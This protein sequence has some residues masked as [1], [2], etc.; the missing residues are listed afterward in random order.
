MRVSGYRAAGRAGTGS[1]TTHEPAAPHRRPFG[2]TVLDLGLLS[3]AVDQALQ[4]WLFDDM[5]PGP[6]LPPVGASRRPQQHWTAWRRV[7]IR[8]IFRASQAEAAEQDIQ[9]CYLRAMAL[10]ITAWT[11]R[12]QGLTHISAGHAACTT[13]GAASRSGASANCCPGRL[14]R[15][16]AESTGATAVVQHHSARPDWTPSVFRLKAHFRLVPCL[17]AP[18]PSR[19]SGATN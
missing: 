16:P 12:T 6:S 7:K 19:R 1:S 14:P 10:N 4:R 13:G 3:M 5:Q 11:T 15:Y 9:T 18:D 2:P 8:A 17:A